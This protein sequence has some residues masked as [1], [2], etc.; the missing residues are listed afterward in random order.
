M[1]VCSAISG[2]AI[3]CLNPD[4]VEGKSVRDMKRLLAL[5]IDVPRFRQR[6][7]AED[8][9]HEILD[10]EIVAKV[11]ERVQIVL[12]E[13]E[14]G[15]GEAEA[16]AEIIVA[17]E[18]HDSVALEQLLQLPSDPNL[19]DLQG[20]APLHC[21]A[22]HGHVQVIQLLL[23]AGAQK[24][25]TDE[26]GRTAL[27]MAARNGHLEV[28]HLLMEAGLDSNRGRTD[29]GATPLHA[30]TQERHLEVARL[31]MEAG[32]D[33]NRGT[34]DTGITPLYIA[35]RNGHLEVVRLIVE[36]GALCDQATTDIGETPLCVAARKGHSEVVRV[37]IEASPLK[38][39]EQTY[40]GLIH[41]ARK[42]DLTALTAA[43][44]RGGA[45]MVV[46]QD[47]FDGNLSAIGYPYDA[48][49][50]EMGASTK[51]R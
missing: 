46:V 9:S 17:S 29:I 33:C 49:G 43:W 23:E 40:A 30:A 26:E 14:Q 48:Y 25:S 2:E 20:R 38:D 15:E 5:E 13:L 7:F 19:K 41:S 10:D 36:A 51:F 27:W 42:G 34:T 39:P 32:A 21:A 47:R 24:D 37:L 12:L 35:A 11:P 4:D 16:V 18:A 28:V 22:G 6:L 50:L 8:S 31:V 44:T 1:E 45:R 3:A